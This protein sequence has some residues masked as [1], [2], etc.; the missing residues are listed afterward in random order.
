MT[1]FEV[2]F[3]NKLD[4]EP[5]VVNVFKK[6]NGGWDPVGDVTPD[7]NQHCISIP[8]DNDS[9]TIKVA[10]E[11]GVKDHQDCVIDVCSLDHNCSDP[12]QTPN[13]EGWIIEITHSRQEGRPENEPGTTTVEISDNQP[14]AA[15]I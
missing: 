10:P 13:R 3:V 2:C 14:G 11:G 5:E 15:K 9:I 1:D 7:R 4:N 8:S 6:N 12:E